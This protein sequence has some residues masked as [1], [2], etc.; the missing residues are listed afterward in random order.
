MARTE[1]VRWLDVGLRQH[2]ALASHVI[3]HAGALARRMAKDAEL[4]KRPDR[5]SN[6]EEHQD[7]D[8][9]DLLQPYKLTVNMPPLMRPHG[10]Q[11][12]AGAALVTAVPVR[13]GHVLGALVRRPTVDV[14]IRLLRR[15]RRVF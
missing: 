9:T 1:N 13:L 10:E 11:R 5:T 6:V 8:T 3:K 4:H 7:I 15:R 12:H 2:W 14:C